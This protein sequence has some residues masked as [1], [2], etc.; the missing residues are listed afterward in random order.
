MESGNSEIGSKENGSTERKRLVGAE[1]RR[2]E[3]SMEIRKE[4]GWSK[5]KY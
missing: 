2:L 4:K 3:V 1:T 5:Q